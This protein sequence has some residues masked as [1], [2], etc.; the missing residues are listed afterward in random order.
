MP[1]QLIQDDERLIYQMAGS[2]IHYRRIP[3]RKRAAIVK[4]H[5]ER[6]KTNW[7]AATA[8]ILEYVVLGWKGVQV[9]RQDVPFSPGLVAT[10][11][12]DVLT[13][14]LKLSGGAGDDEILEKNFEPTSSG[15]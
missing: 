7:D 8:E 2:E 15:S 13:E 12:E 3:T 9:K 14:V 5:T 1:I 10:L 4:K 6:G 11:P